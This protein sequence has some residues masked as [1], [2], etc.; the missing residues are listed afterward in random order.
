MLKYNKISDL[1]INGEFFSRLPDLLVDFPN[2]DFTNFDKVFKFSYGNIL[3]N[4]DLTFDVIQAWYLSNINT[5]KAVYKALFEQYSA[6]E[7]KNLKK[8]TTYQE[9]QAPFESNNYI[10]GKRKNTNEYAKREN[11]NYATTYDSTEKR[12]TSSNESKT[13]TD[14]VTVE[15]IA[16]INNKKG[17]TQKTEYTDTTSI[18]FEGETFS[19]HKVNVSCETIS[20]NSGLKSPQE[21]VEKEIILRTNFDFFKYFGNE[22]LK[23]LT[24]NMWG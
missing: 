13:Y 20:G 4:D 3:I 11:E 1:Y 6:I 16:D 12:L 8:V 24:L 23:D 17:E 2:A 22:F 21:L 9:K 14:N 7:D 5:F 19:G 10:N 15:D 18:I